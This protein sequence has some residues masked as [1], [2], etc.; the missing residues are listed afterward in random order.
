MESTGRA[1]ELSAA[2]LGVIAPTSSLPDALE[3]WSA[4]QHALGPGP[5]AVFLDYDGTLTPIRS[6]PEE[7][8]LGDSMRDAVE[9]LARRCFVAVVTGRGMVDV[10]A[11]VGLPQLHYAA[12]HGFEITGPGLSFVPQPTL[13]P[14]FDAL[15]PLVEQLATQFHGT[16]VEHKG[17][18]ISVHYRLTPPEQVPTL[19]ARIDRLLA[20]HASLRKGLGKKVFEL[21]PA[22]D[23]HKGAAVRWLLEHAGSGSAG[24]GPLVPVYIGDDRTDEDAL[25]AV[26]DDGVG[27]FVGQ[28][29][30]PSAA[31]FG[32]SDPDAVE[33]LLRRLAEASATSR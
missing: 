13:R 17:F 24:P 32:L 33:V 21:R 14:T 8:T 18:S 1:G 28:P 6:R 30:W 5:W 3:H 22:I 2:T 15:R 20:A 4:L 29:A 19:E 10:R 11:L 25:A 16:L 12:S 27:I 26:A 23:W 7:A 9:G 31:R